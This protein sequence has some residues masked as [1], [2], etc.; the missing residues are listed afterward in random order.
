MNGRSPAIHG[1]NNRR[2]WNGGIVPE[3]TEAPDIIPA[4]RRRNDVTSLLLRG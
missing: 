2:R 4:N 1:R 3:E